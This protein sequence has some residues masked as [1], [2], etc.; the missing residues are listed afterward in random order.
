MPVPDSYLQALLAAFKQSMKLLLRDSITIERVKPGQQ[1]CLL[2]VV[3]LEFNWQDEPPFFIQIKLLPLEGTG[4]WLETIA[5]SAYQFSLYDDFQSIL[6]ALIS[7]QGYTTA[8]TYAPLPPPS[9]QKQHWCTYTHQFT[10]ESAYTKYQCSCMKGKKQLF[11]ALSK[12]KDLLGSSKQ[13]KVDGSGR[14]Y[15]HLSEVQPPCPC[16]QSPSAGQVIEVSIAE[17]S[18]TGST[19]LAVHPTKEFSCAG[20]L[21]QGNAPALA[22]KS[23]FGAVP[24]GMDNDG[25]LS[26]AQ[27][28]SRHIDVSMLQHYRQYEDVLLQAPPSFPSDHATPVPDPNPPGDPTD[29]SISTCTLLQALPFHTACNVFRL[30]HQFF[31]SIPPSHDPEE[32]VTLHNISSVSVFTPAE[33]D[34]PITDNAFYPYPNKSSFELSDWYWNGS[35]QKSKDGFKELIGIV[36]HPDFDPD[37]LGVSGHDE[38]DKWKDENAGWC[39]APVT[40]EVPFSWTTAQ[41][42]AQTYVAAELYHRPLIPI[43]RKKLSNPQDDELF[44]YEPYQ[45]KWNAPHLPHEVNIHGELYTLSAFMDMHHELQESPGEAGYTMQLTTFGNAAS[46]LWPVYISACNLGNHVA[47]FQKGL[48]MIAQCIANFTHEY[49]PTLLT[50][51]RIRCIEGSSGG[52][53]MQPHPQKNLGV[54][55][56]AVGTLLKPNSW[57][58]LSDGLSAFGFNLFAALIVNLLHKVELGDLIHKLDK[59]YRQVPPFGPATI[60][61]FSA[62]TS[63]MSHKA[64]WNF[65]DLLQCSILVFE[66]LLPEP[67][68]KI[69]IDLLFVMAHWHGL[70]KLCMHS[71]L[72]LDILDQQTTELVNARSRRQTKEA[73]KRMEKGRANGSKA[74]VPGP[75]AGASLK[76][77]QKAAPEQS[78]DAPLPR[79]PKKKKSFNL[80]TYKLHV[81]GDYVA[82]ICRLGTMDSYSTELGE[83]EHRTLKGRLSIIKQDYAASNGSIN[84]LLIQHL[85]KLQVIPSSTISSVKDF[86]PQLKDH[87]LDRLNPGTSRT[88]ESLSEK[89]AHSDTEYSSILFKQNRIYHHNLAKFNYT[90]YNIRRA[91][92]V[93]NPKTAYCNIMLLQH[94]CNDAL[95]GNYCYARVLGIYHV[96]VVQFLPLENLNTFGFMDPGDV[97]QSNS[98]SPLARDKHD[99]HEYYVNSFIDCDTLMWFHHG[100]GV[101]HLYSHRAGV[102][103]LEPCS[104]SQASA[105][106]E[107]EHVENIT[108]H[109]VDEEDKEDKEDEDY[110]GAEELILLEQ[111]QNESTETVIDALEEMY[112]DHMFDYEN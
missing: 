92:D 93:V 95:N 12:A 85:M 112:A 56:V 20:L 24:M 39:K 57:N 73:A 4:R 7:H 13:S 14:P 64:A 102:F 33:P 28:R 30:V 62:N 54:D 8:S 111:G 103:D 66:G 25:N 77:K 110:V 38:G 52:H 6:L 29:M 83:L 61:Q 9:A 87:I 108:E 41:P 100:L 59:R 17:P 97:L 82:S 15:A 71:D 44:H 22:S 16:D 3:S 105:L 104:V 58:V 91:Q 34:S 36:G 81:L 55:S 48:A 50:I 98:I 2:P 107:D 40:I 106:T 74:V 96:N 43:I 90:T 109:P 1:F 19:L 46:R 88:S 27:R 89:P 80:Q 94:D 42:G 49:L 5:G 70:A 37:A 84:G 99:W 60:R 75:R 10:Q 11:S 78:Q 76:G 68:N 53:R 79:Q 26:L 23:D 65:E 47:Y 21:S 101:G 18:S 72:T 31:S 67:H 32:A 35:V 45:L 51:L 86:L 63:E 69:I